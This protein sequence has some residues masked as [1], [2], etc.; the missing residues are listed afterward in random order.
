M[1]YPHRWT[2]ALLIALVA[3]ISTVYLITNLRTTNGQLIAPLDDA[4]ITFQYARQIAQGQPYQYNDGDP[5]TTGMTSPL[6]GFLLAGIYRI[7]FNGERLVAFAVGLGVIWLGLIGWLTYRLAFHLTKKRG[8]A[9]WGT[10][11]ILLTGPVQWG[12]FNGMETGLFIT[13]TLA[14]LYASLVKKTSLC[15][16]CL[17]L[18]GLTRPEG[19][20]LAG[21]IWLSSLI[22]SLLCFHSINWK[23]Q[24]ILSM[25]VG[26]GLAPTIVTWI[27]TGKTAS[28]GLLAKSWQYNVPYYP[29]DIARSILNSYKE[30][31]Y[32]FVGWQSSGYRL[33]PPGLFLLS[34]IGWIGLGTQ[35]RW[36]SLFLTLCWFLV[37]TLSTATLITADWHLGRY[38]L[39]FIAT[40]VAISAMG[41]SLLYHQAKERWQQISLTSIAFILI[42]L[43]IH[44]LPFFIRSYQTAIKTIVQQHLQVVNWIRTNIPRDYRIGI[45]DAG[46]LRYL[47]NNPTYDLIGL[48]T[49]DAATSW[50][51]GSGS[52]FEL[53]EQSP[54]R[55]HYFALFPD[56]SIIPY[57]KATDLFAEELYKLE[58]S[59]IGISSPS[60]VKGVWRADWHLA[61]SGETFYQ[62]DIITRTAGLEIVDKLDVAD[63]DDEAAHNVEWWQAVKR[64][65]FPTEVQQMHYRVIPTQEVLDGGR[66]LTGGMSFAIDS[67]PDEP[68]WIIA[69]LHAREA[70]AVQVIVD[71]QKI[72]R[73]AYPQIPGQWLET[74][75]RVPAS[76]ITASQTE[77]T[78]QVDA[79]NPAFRHYA[80]YYLWVLQGRPAREAVKIQHNVNVSFDERLRLIG[81]DLSKKS[82]R[83]GDVVSL[84]LYWQTPTPTDSDA[85]VFLHFYDS[86]GQIKAQSDSRAYFG[87]RPPYTWAPGETVIDPRRL[88]LPDDLPP[89]QYSI[90]VGL[91]KPD[92][93]S[94]LQAY[95]N[96][97]LQSQNRVLLK[98]IEITE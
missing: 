40:L 16:L 75:F 60:R 26:I 4:Y 48:T 86:E 97:V 72:G 5:P 50:R 79:D 80:P 62:P 31:L 54:T 56:I 8:W 55:P 59:N 95:R 21:L 96:S 64:P 17:G 23:R 22:D 1:K 68:I 14:A 61:G 58:I 15:A 77:I 24:T 65:G 10:V 2:I 63:L 13:L 20:I 70:G 38:Q 78:L 45:T 27:L 7:G 98:F 34:L 94:R 3:L 69:R 82:W 28:T 89:G 9:L 35:K 42:I 19:L 85:K 73:W 6:F 44:P 74:I 91:Y 29:G 46:V 47:G 57:L 53:M 36:V 81:F 67:N 37:G 39:P 92:G 41:L 12:C 84:N 93:G 90:E 51:H 32:R 66:L 83:P 87:T 88:T 71:G 76:A 18:A 33:A 30:I 11:L 25:A 52:V 43:S 49:P